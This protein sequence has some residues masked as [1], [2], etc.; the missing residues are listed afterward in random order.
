[1]IREWVYIGMT[2]DIERRI[3]EHNSGKNK[4]TKPYA[5]FKLVYT[6]DH[7]DRISARKREKYLKTASGKRW[8]K[9]QIVD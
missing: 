8:L 6:E 4:G 2:S 3:V 9:Y 7:P 5:P 1:M